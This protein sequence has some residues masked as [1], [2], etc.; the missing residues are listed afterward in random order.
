VVSKQL[1]TVNAVHR[2][3]QE[4]MV[5]AIAS[6][7]GMDA[8]IIEYIV[9]GESRITRKPLHSTQ[10]PRGAIVGA[11]MRDDEFIVPMGDTQVQS[12]DRVVMFTL[13]GALAA[14]EKLFK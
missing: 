9:D 2:F 8:Q 12:G 13:P 3:I 5:A 10:F 4:Q 7:P 14:V 11:L 6:V 1:L